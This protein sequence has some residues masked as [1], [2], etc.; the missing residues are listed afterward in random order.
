[1]N[2]EVSKFKTLELA[3]STFL[4]LPLGVKENET[5]K[6]ATLFQCQDLLCENTYFSFSWEHLT[7]SYLYHLLVYIVSL[8][9]GVLI[10]L[11]LGCN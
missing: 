8:T 2:F 5:L 1:M 7:V 4:G 9:M 3:R 6:Q 10:L 11:Q